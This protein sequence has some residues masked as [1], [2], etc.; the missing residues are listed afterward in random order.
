VLL[1]PMKLLLS[2]LVFAYYDFACS[3]AIVII[4]VEDARKLFA[5]KSDTE[6]TYTPIVMI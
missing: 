2:F 4:V 3:I 6:I 1:H 5:L